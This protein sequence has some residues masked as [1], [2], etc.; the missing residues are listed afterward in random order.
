M[1]FSFRLNWAVDRTGKWQELEYP[2]PAYPAFACGSGYVISKD[3]V[4]WLASNSE[5]L[6]TYQV[7]KIS[8]VFCDK[9]VWGAACTGWVRTCGLL[10]HF[11]LL[12]LVPVLG[13]ST[14]VFG[15][16]T[17]G[18]VILF[19]VLCFW[20]NSVLSWERREDYF[21]TSAVVRHSFL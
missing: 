8:S 11:W 14:G 15:L 13:Q 19:F 10:P 20:K 5:R 12:C 16:R 3:I 21:N 6:K 17:S 2:S 1:V 7:I 18:V 4:Q 9:V